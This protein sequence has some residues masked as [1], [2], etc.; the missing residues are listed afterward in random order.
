MSLMIGFDAY[1]SCFWEKREKTVPLKAKNLARSTKYSS[2]SQT[3]WDDDKAN[4]GPV[5]RTKE[6]R[7]S[8]DRPPY[9]LFLATIQKLLHR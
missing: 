8:G 3:V 9:P 5:L 2:R 1:R 7:S 6:R 4:G